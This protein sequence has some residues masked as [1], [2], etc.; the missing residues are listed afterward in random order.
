[1]NATNRHDMKGGLL[2]SLGHLSW[3]KSV[4]PPIAEV[5]KAKKLFGC[6]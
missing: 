4:P 6:K 5:I 3:E 1:M 2:E